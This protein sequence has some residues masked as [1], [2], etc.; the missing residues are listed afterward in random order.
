MLPLRPFH[1]S[2]PATIDELMH[3]L[4]RAHERTKIIA[5]GTDVLPNLKH[6]LYHIDELIS[7][8]KIHPFKH[9]G[10]RDDG[11]EIGALVTL[12]QLQRHSL[13][14]ARVPVL[15]RAAAQIASPQIRAMG[16]VG[17]NICLDTRCL[18]INQ[19]EFWRS[20][21]GYCLKKDGTCC[22]VVKTG[23]RCVAA[24][25]NDLATAL[26]ALNAQVNLLSPTGAKAIALDDFYTANGEKNTVLATNEI[27][28]SVFVPLRKNQRAGFFKLRHR[29]SIDFPLLST[30]LSFMLDEQHQ[31]KSGTLVVNALVSKPK[32]MDLADFGGSA[33]NDALIERIAEYAKKKCH[34]QTNICGDTSWR[35]EMVA[36]S[37]K[38]A[39]FEALTR[40]EAC[41]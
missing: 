5:G 41:S 4:E 24:A 35:K 32:V 40:N 26:I 8:H 20:A 39:F 13:I 12:N 2:E 30:A 31:L 21:L 23:K 17:G 36:Y 18:Y 6:G 25:S 33:Y 16:T 19:T 11:V 22:H 28:T 37:V 14:A 15:G 9:V 27:V 34:P 29:E 7:L 10:E 1:L 3:L 38:T